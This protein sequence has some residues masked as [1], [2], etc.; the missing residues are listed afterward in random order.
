MK[1]KIVLEYDVYEIYG[2][3]AFLIIDNMQGGWWWW[4]CIT[5]CRLSGY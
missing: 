4:W 5:D 1:T 2:K 3:N